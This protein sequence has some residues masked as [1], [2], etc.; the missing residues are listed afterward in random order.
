MEYSHLQLRQ[1]EGV[2]F[3]E[4]DNGLGVMT[5]VSP[6]CFCCWCSDAAE[7]GQDSSGKKEPSAKI[8]RPVLRNDLPLMGV[9]KPGKE[10]ILFS[11][12]VFRGA[13]TFRGILLLGR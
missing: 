8:L 6:F 1:A 13:N 5:I 2:S 3:R 12:V 4:F 7:S 10:H 9:N 11:S